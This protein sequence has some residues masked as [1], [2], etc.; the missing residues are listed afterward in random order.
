MFDGPIGTAFVYEFVFI[1]QFKYPATGGH[2]IQG[3]NHRCK[4]NGLAV[5]VLEYRI[6]LAKDGIDTEVYLDGFLYR[7]RHISIDNLS[8][9]FHGV[10]LA[11]CDLGCV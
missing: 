6:P 7:C 3:I 8:E 4:T 9:V 10:G 11:K 1:L 5:L 2:E